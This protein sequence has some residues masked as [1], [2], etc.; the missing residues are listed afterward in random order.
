MKV[1]MFTLTLTSLFGL[2]LAIAAP[3]VKAQSKALDPFTSNPPAEVPSSSLLELDPNSAQNPAQ[4][5]QSMTSSTQTQAVPSTFVTAPLTKMLP[6][7]RTVVPV[8]ATFSPSSQIQD[9]KDTPA[10]VPSAN[11]LNY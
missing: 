10:E 6:K 1:S 11:L 7:Q 5:E 8:A 2:T 3:S 4:P 9:P